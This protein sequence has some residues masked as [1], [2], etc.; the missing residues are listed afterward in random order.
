MAYLV[1]RLHRRSP[2]REHQQPLCGWIACS[3]IALCIWVPIS[4]RHTSS[5]ANL[6]DSAML[7]RYDSPPTHSARCSTNP[8]ARRLLSAEAR[9]IFEGHRSHHDACEPQ[10]HWRVGEL[11]EMF[12]TKHRAFW[13][14]TS[15]TLTSS[16]NNCGVTR[17][18][19]RAG[20]SSESTLSERALLRD[21]A[22]AAVFGGVRCGLV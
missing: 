8:P 19:W 22:G 15:A 21:E 2:N 13:S 18:L 11:L 16:S 6:A 17:W 20:R 9:A 12:L 7:W 4:R 10:R 1:P 5:P 3:S 14:T